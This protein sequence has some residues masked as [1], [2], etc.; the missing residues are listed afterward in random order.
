[1]GDSGSFS[2]FPAVPVLDPA[3]VA[4]LRDTAGEHF[5]PF[6]EELREL[7][8]REGEHQMSALRTACQSRRRELLDRAAHAFAGTAANIGAERLARLCLQIERGRDTLSW[9]QASALVGEVERVFGQTR[10]ALHSPLASGACRRR[11]P[12]TG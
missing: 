4:S 11:A 7:F 3:Y 12:D 1:M 6:F 9:E 8:E 2:A 5:G 10:Q